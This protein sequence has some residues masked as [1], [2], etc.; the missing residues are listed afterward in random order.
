MDLQRKKRKVL[1]MDNAE[2]KVHQL[3]VEGLVECA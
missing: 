1:T 3:I 2:K